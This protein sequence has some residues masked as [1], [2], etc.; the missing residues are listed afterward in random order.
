MPNPANTTVR[1]GSRKDRL[2][3]ESFRVA[4][5]TIK[6]RIDGQGK[7]IPDALYEFTGQQ[8]L[9]YLAFAYREGRKGPAR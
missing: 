2:M 1:P 7:F 9:E 4:Q 6:E 5:Q 8:L 3:Q